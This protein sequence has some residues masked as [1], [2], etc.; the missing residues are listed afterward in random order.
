MRVK[1]DYGIDLG[2]TNSAIARMEQGQ[3][4][5][6][7]SDVQMDTVPSCVHFNKKQS[8][9]TGIQAQTALK[10]ERVRALREGSVGQLNSFI[11]FKRTM[12]TTETYESTHMA[13]S[14]TS[15]ELSAD[16]LRALR[17]H[18]QDEGF[19]S[20]VITVPAKFTT[21][22]NNATKHAAMLAGFKQVHLLQEPV[23]A[24]TA[25]GL[26]ANS[27]EGVWLV[28][29]FGGG[30][31][32]AAIIKNEEGV[33][34]VKDTE[35]DNF[36][37]GKNLD[38]AIID[39]LLIPYL[40]EHYQ[41]QSMLQDSMSRQR[42][43]DALKGRAE[44]AKIKLSSS[45]SFNILTE[46]DE[47][48]EDEEGEEMEL[49]LTL[50]RSDMERVL[51][52]IFQKAVDITLELLKRN[53]LRGSDLSALLLVG[54][55]THS[56]VLRQMLREQVTPNVDTSVDP[57]TVVACGAALFASTLSIDDHIQ[58]AQ[59]DKS[60]LQLNLKFDASTTET[61]PMVNVSLLRSKCEGYVPDKL[62]ISF[63][64]MDGAFNT[65]PSPLTENISL[66]DLELV[67]GRTNLFNIVVRD[68]G[69]HIVE[70]EPSEISIL[71][72]LSGLDEMQV[73][74]YHVGIGRYY[75]EFES[76]RFAP[77]RGLEKN[78]TMPAVGTINGLKTK[79]EIR[80]GMSSDVIRIPIY[81]GDYNA[82]GS[83][84]ELNN[85]V[86]E[87][88]ITGEC[89]PKTLPAG[90]P[91]D[92]T[93]KVDRSGTIVVEAEFPSIEHSEELKAEI[94]S[95]QAPSAEALERAIR[96]AV[97]RAHRFNLSEVETELE[98]L[99]KQLEHERAS[100]DGR[101]R[102][103]EALRKQLLLID[104]AER[105]ASWATVE[106]ELKEALYE[107]EELWRK[108]KANGDDKQ[109]NVD[110][111]EKELAEC[112]QRAELAIREQNVKEA[113][114]VSR[115]LGALDHNLRNAVT[116][117]EQDAQVLQAI[118]QAFHTLQ[119]R[120]PAKAK[121]LI[122]QGLQRIQSGNNH[123][124]DILVELVHHNMVSENDG[125]DLLGG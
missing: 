24:A 69:G 95:M 31:F 11:E 97:G 100:G 18:I 51:T 72:G 78:K 5:V 29:D 30:T 44:E 93:I 22:Q 107:A 111:V 19:E 54:G 47:L 82:E 20:V 125:A 59:R 56:P 37:G 109:I 23:A 7:K 42:L 98:V 68:G 79:S 48:T 113:R 73:L 50:T 112:R 65:P 110:A 60:K 108:I 1:I 103:Q 75:E 90:S 83:T 116:G 52:P 118:N 74:P 39:E 99:Q 9:L 70:C 124:R 14:Y 89:M 61:D 35:G 15:E 64:R 34:S 122:Q 67:E 106:E 16:V 32:D 66:V 91:V 62:T 27:K 49:D 33:L 40:A 26:S 57:M 21:P 55:P 105:N 104:P 53:N 3:P 17:T 2:T 4:V 45:E 6:K 38:E 13:R 117:G 77:A 87:L 58:E 71:Q 114:E 85:L 12:G 94:K 96:K 120:N 121:E 63:Q 81:Q 41:I 86:V 43:R 119:W 88:L 25:Y 102:L 36:L 92:L 84:P 46:L 101:L 8:T 76:E 28:F 123:V 115:S 10:K 80:A